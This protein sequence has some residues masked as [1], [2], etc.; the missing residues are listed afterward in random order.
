MIYM[1]LHIDLKTPLLAMCIF[2]FSIQLNAQAT[3]SAPTTDILLEEVDA[4][5]SLPDENWKKQEVTTQ[6][7]GQN[8]N[9]VTYSKTSNGSEM[10]LMINVIERKTDAVARLFKEFNKL[11][12][13]GEHDEEADFTKQVLG[14]DF[15]IKDLSSATQPILKDFKGASVL[16]LKQLIIQSQAILWR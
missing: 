10:N 11:L 4:K 13:A 14:L 6:Q 7:E 3:N 1:Y 16:A 8:L 9:A 5:L 2:L 15:N 12:G